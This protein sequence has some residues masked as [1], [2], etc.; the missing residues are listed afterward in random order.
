MLH[1]KP[2][3]ELQ[4]FASQMRRGADPGARVVELIRTGLGLGDQILK[5]GNAAIGPDRNHI[6]GSAER[7]D[8]GEISEGIIGRV[9][10]K[11]GVHHE[12]AGRDQQRIAIPRRAGDIA[13]ADIGPGAAAILDHHWPAERLAQRRGQNAG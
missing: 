1:F 13:N 11:T 3:A 10:I 7:A 8:R 4:Q 5:R 2:G 12:G 9:T 6:G